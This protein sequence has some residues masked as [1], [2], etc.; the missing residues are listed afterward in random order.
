MNTRPPGRPGPNLRVILASSSSHLPFHLSGNLAVLPSQHILDLVS[1]ITHRWWPGSDGCRSPSWSPVWS[2]P[3][4]SPLGSQSHPLKARQMTSFHCS[5]RSTDVPS[6]P[7]L[8]P[9]TIPG[10]PRPNI[11]PSS[12]P[13]TPAMLIS[14]KDPGMLLPRAWALTVPSAWNVPS[15]RALD[16]ATTPFSKALSEHPSITAPPVLAHPRLAILLH[17]ST[18]STLQ[19]AFA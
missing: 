7:E 6:H 17:F 16:H 3:V 15:G 18:L 1:S 12:A 9:E 13:A 10:P 19:T 8:K 14:L 2:P 5:G 4:Y 11:C